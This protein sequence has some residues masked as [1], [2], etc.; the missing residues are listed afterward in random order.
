MTANIGNHSSDAV[1]RMNGSL[2]HTVCAWIC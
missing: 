1:L 2:L